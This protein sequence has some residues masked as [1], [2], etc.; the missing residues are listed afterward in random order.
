VPGLH[1]QSVDAQLPY[2][3]PWCDVKHGAGGTGDW[4]DHLMMARAGHLVGG[5]PEFDGWPRWD[6][7]THQ[8][9]F[10]SCLKRAVDGGLRSW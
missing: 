7:L 10:E 9:M 3:L 6:S 4:T 5:Y 8:G 1:G 2:A